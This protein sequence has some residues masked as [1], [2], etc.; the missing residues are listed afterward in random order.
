MT[1][2]KFDAAMRDGPENIEWTTE[3]DTGKVLYSSRGDPEWVW[4]E[5]GKLE[6]SDVFAT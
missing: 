3:G 4:C 6:C 2:E 1:Q 5:Q